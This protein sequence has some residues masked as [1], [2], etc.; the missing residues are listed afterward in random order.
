MRRI[1][2]TVPDAGRASQPGAGRFNSH[3]RAM[4]PFSSRGRTFAVQVG[5]VWVNDWAKV[6]DE[7]LAA[8]ARTRAHLGHQIDER[9]R[10]C[11]RWPVRGQRKGDLEDRRRLQVHYREAA[12][13]HQQ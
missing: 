9:L 1:N 3:R 11:L 8:V 12:L 7:V 6:Y 13:A 10:R 5:T 2:G 4:A